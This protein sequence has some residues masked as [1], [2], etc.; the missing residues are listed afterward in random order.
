VR[1]AVALDG[2]PIVE[3][4]F[5]P[6]GIW[7]DGNSVAIERIPIEPGEHRVRVSIGESTDPEEWSFSEERVLDFDTEARRIVVFD[8]VAGFGWH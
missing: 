2:T 1:L 5:P 8:R 3:T 6:G 7:G 4:S